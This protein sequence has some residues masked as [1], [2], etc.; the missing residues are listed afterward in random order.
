[1][2]WP[3]YWCA[4]GHYSAGRPPPQDFCPNI[5]ALLEVIIRNTHIEVGIHSTINFSGISYPIPPKTAHMSTSKLDCSLNQPVT[6]AF[7]LFF[8]T[9]FLPSDQ[10]NLFQPSKAQCWWLLSKSNLSLC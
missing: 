9:H 6:K 3:F 4:W 1:M 7:P 10:I 5:E 2:S 8:H